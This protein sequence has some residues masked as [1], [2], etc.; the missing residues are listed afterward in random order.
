MFGLITLAEILGVIIIAGGLVYYQHTSTSNPA[1]YGS[2]GIPGTGTLQLPAGTVDVTLSAGTVSQSITVPA[3]KI[4]VVSES[5]GRP[6]SLR[7]VDG[8]SEDSYAQVAAVRIPAAGKYN[9][10]VTGSD[11]AVP[12]PQL[13]FGIIGQQTGI[14]IAALIVGGLL[15]LAS[16]VLTILRRRAGGGW[17]PTKYAGVGLNLNH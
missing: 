10:A 14:L 8:A 13:G 6:E 1:Q 5:T 4:S 11:P 2:V 7:F 16:L 3:F 12:Y 15:L 9:V 17:W